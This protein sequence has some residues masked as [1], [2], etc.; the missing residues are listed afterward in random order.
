MGIRVD[1]EPLLK[2]L[3][4]TG[5]EKRLHPLFHHR[6]MEDEL[7]LSMGGGIGQ[8]RVGMFML[9]KAHVGEISAG[10]WPEE[11]VHVC[12]AHGIRLL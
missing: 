11:M 2:Q 4:I 9:R 1:I 7:L 10:I 8:S 5:Q 3:H 6:L 12:K